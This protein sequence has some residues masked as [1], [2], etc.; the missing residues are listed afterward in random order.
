[1]DK[2]DNEIDE[3]IEY[4]G[5]LLDHGDIEWT[6]EAVFLAVANAGHG[7]SIASIVANEVASYHKW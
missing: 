7:E 3:L 6:R 5:E 2:I 4:V 1:M